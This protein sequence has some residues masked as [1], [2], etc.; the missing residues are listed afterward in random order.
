MTKTTQTAPRFSKPM[1]EGIER[2]RFMLAQDFQWPVDVQYQRD[3]ATGE[4]VAV[5]SI[6]VIPA[7]S[8]AAPGPIGDIKR[9]TTSDGA[10]YSV[11]NVY[12]VTV[13]DGLTSAQALKLSRYMI[14]AEAPGLFDGDGARIFSTQP[15]RAMHGVVRDEDDA[16]DGFS[17]S[18]RER[19]DDI[20]RDISRAIQWP[21]SVAY[22]CADEPAEQWAAFVLD[23]APEGALPVSIFIGDRVKGFAAIVGTD[24]RT[25][26]GY[27]ETEARFMDDA[28]LY[29]LIHETVTAEFMALTTRRKRRDDAALI[30]LAL[31]AP[32]Q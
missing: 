1:R 32:V 17:E 19:L 25:V 12:D 8:I 13:V 11:G 7:G 5:F 26:L 21:V 22:G 16:A 10:R 20:R 30:A 3:A 27:V 24:P 29:R 28:G 15:E 14:G 4:P 18:L 6:N 23:I 9:N 2:L 31:G